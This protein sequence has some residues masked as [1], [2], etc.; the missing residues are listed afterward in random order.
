MNR[1]RFWRNAFI[2]LAALIVISQTVLMVDQSRQGVVLRFGKPV[3]VLNANGGK[4]GLKAK[5]PF[6]DQVTVFDKRNQAL[7]T[8]PVE[9]AAADQRQLVVDAF[10]RYRIDDPLRLYRTVHDQKTMAARLNRLATA[11]LRRALAKAGSQDI[12]SGRRDALSR[13]ARD[14]MTG[15]AA[16]MG[17]EVIDL[18]IRRADLPAADQN[19]IFERMSGTWRQQAAEVRAGTEQQRQQILAEAGAKAE[20]VR[21]ETAVAKAKIFASSYGRDPEFAAF[22]QTMQ[23]YDETLARGDTTV[24]LPQGSEFFK[25]LQHGPQPANSSAR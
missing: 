8:E 22:Y 2:V 13:S 9:L 17:V 14:D 7:Q 19:A 6:V 18:R 16:G 21:A 11:S 4:P 25:Y 20:A 5:I 10:V 12:L 23:A 15:P 3:R 24:V 1:D